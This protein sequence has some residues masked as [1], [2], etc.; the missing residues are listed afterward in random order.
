MRTQTL[1]LLRCP[2]GC[3]GALQL[4]TQETASDRILSGRLD[5]PGCGQSYPI[6]SGMARMLPGALSEDT[7][8]AASSEQTQD[9][10]TARKKSEMKARDEQVDAYDRMRGL[11]LF[12]KVEIPVTLSQLA[13]RPKDILLEAGCG[14][15][16]MTSIFARRC[17][18][19][20]AIDFSWESLRVCKRK[21]DAAGIANVDLI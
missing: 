16:R 2:L 14:T 5:C 8:L 4:T 1:A 20:I 21:L 10:E 19:Q 7:P 6:A 11:A 12:G 15:G 17:A 9:T 3:E 18:S 13:L